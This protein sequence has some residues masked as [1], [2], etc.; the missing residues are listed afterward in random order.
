MTINSNF[1]LIILIILVIIFILQ[2]YLPTNNIFFNKGSNNILDN[3]WSFEKYTPI[4]ID[5]AAAAAAIE[6]ADPADA[7]A[8]Y[9]Y[10]AA[11]YAE[12]AAPQLPYNAS[13][14]D[15]STEPPAPHNS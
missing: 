9:A 10:A 7:A 8:P 6:Y 3:R 14:V 5:A 4:H 1:I 2:F 11:P 15:G 12:P 13:A